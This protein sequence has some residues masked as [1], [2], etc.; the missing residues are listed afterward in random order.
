HRQ[1]GA[2]ALASSEVL[3]MPVWITATIIAAAVGSAA[4]QAPLQA[5]RFDWTR[6]AQPVG[7]VR[8]TSYVLGN[9]DRVLRH[10]VDVAASPS[11]VWRAFT[12]SEGLRGFA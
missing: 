12:T 8:N 2:P 10:E 4:A 5:E 6:P 3:I 11:A 1:T 9:G 7:A